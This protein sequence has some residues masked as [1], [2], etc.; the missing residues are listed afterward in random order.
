MVAFVG[1]HYSRCLWIYK[2]TQFT[3]C[4]RDGWGFWC[5]VFNV[6]GR[7]IAVVPK[8][9]KCEQGRY[10]VLSKYSEELTCFVKTVLSTFENLFQ[11]QPLATL[12]LPKTR[13]TIELSGLGINYYPYPKKSWKNPTHWFNSVLKT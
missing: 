2:V 9:S 7:G 11:H 4:V 12:L 8:S 13:F 3:V 1:A 10:L 6:L 5:K